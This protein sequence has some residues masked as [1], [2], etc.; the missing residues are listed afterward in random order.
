MKV[1]VN[2]LY[3]YISVLLDRSS[4]QTNL[5]S[6]DIVRVIPIREPGI[7]RRTCPVSPGYRTT[8][9]W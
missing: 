6:G 9:W 5:Q 7:V 8:D 4:A 3:T 2:Q 1:R